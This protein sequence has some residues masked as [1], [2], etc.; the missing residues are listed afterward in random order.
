MN[1]LVDPHVHTTGSGHAYSTISEIAA[2]AKEKGLKIIGMT[3]HG[4]A[5]LCGADKFYFL[6]LRT[7]GDTVNGVRVLKGIEAN[8]LNG[9]G[10][11]DLTDAMYNCIELVI[12]S[13][14][15]D[16]FR[17]EG[18]DTCMAAIMHAID[19][20]RVNILGHLDD[21]RYNLDY[22]P[23][24]QRAAKKRVLIEINNSSLSPH[25]VRQKAQENITKMLSICKF[26]NTPV[27][28]GSDAHFHTKVGE[29]SMAMKIMEEINFPTELVMN[30]TPEK[31]LEHIKD[32]L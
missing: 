23:V 16:F 5:S 26:L 1:L 21:A 27:I 20:P 13:I 31:F 3:D 9:G 11:L 2:T 30:Y 24:I 7:I 17:S 25:S 8:I 32:K 18:P 12:A 19:N 6:N 4:P 14:H 10:E 28:L 29:F 15:L 22:E